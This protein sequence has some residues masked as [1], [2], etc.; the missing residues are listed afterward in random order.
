MSV[1]PEVQPPVLS[2]TGLIRRFGDFVA[3]S[4]VKRLGM[5]A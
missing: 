3:L 5:M 1:S 2:V 4:D